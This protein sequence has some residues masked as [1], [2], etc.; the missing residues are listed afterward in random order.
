MSRHNSRSQSTSTSSLRGGDAAGKPARRRE[1]GVFVALQS[2]LFVYGLIRFVVEPVLAWFRNDPVAVPFHAEA[3]VT[4][5][6]LAHVDFDSNAGL[7]ADIAPHGSARM[8]LL[9]L[10]LLAFLVLVIAL[11]KIRMIGRAV[12]TGEPFTKANV[13]RWRVLAGCA[14]FGGLVWPLAQHLLNVWVAETA[15][16]A[17]GGTLDPVC[18]DF[19]MLLAACVCVLMAEGFSH[20]AAM[21]EDLEG[22]I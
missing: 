5:A 7:T 1:S 21:R 22:V 18:F 2:F 8:A 3:K 11:W 10:S 14:V 9:L 19:G 4:D 17:V 13:A 6:T 15:Y 16:P 12:V 20:G